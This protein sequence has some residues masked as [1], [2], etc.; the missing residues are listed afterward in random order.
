MGLGRVSR[1]R[2]ALWAR[3]PVWGIGCLAACTAEEY[4]NADLQLD[5]LAAL[6]SAGEQVRICVEG[7]GSHSVGAGGDRYGFAGVPISEQVQVTADVLVQEGDD[8]GL[9]TMLA[10]ARATDVALSAEFPYR[11][12]EL[13]IFSSDGALPCASCP[14]AC[15]PEGS[16]AG[17]EEES[18]LLAVRF[19][20]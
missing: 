5:I 15:D 4:R 14:V 7:V 11:E 3:W 16:I 13:E 17:E 10:I 8:S 1:G 2:W 6:P 18:W 19:M 9:P 12:V 20:E